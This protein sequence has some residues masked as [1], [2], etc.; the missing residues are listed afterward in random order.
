MRRVV[1]ESPFAGDVARN[2][3]YLRAC[4][5]DCLLR[6]EAPFASHGLYTQPGVLDDDNRMDRG[7][8]MDA[9]FAWGELADATVVYNDLGVTPGMEEGILRAGARG[10]PVDIRALG[11]DWETAPI[12]KT[13]WG[14]GESEVVAA[15][16]RDLAATKVDLKL[17]L[18]MLRNAAENLDDRGVLRVVDE[19][20]GRIA[21]RSAG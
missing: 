15:L 9:G 14:S 17:V 12:Y 21:S 6:G 3:H 2:L 18:A 10:R 11:P 13:R 16:E 7:L 8:G 4:M 20:Y 1:L 19:L 5:R